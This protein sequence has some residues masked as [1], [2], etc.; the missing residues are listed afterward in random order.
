MTEER[1]VLSVLY[2]GLSGIPL[3]PSY[4]VEFHL[5]QELILPNDW[6]L[7]EGVPSPKKDINKGVGCFTVFVVVFNQHLSYCQNKK[8]SPCK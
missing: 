6:L 3:Y 8:K 2:V 4:R 5:E 7:G 1:R